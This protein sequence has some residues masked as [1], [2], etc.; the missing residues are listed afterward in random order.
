MKIHPFMKGLILLILVC[1]LTAASGCHTNSPWVLPPQTV[2]FS[3]AEVLSGTWTNYNGRVMRLIGSVVKSSE[4]GGDFMI[5]KVGD[6]ESKE[7]YFCQI[8]QVTH[9]PDD[10]YRGGTHNIY[11]LLARTGD[12]SGHFL[13]GGVKMEDRTNEF[14]VTVDFRVNPRYIRFVPSPFGSGSEATNLARD[15]LNDGVLYDFT[16]TKNYRFRESFWAYGGKP[17]IP[18]DTGLDITNLSRIDR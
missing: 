2:G 12:M 9:I 18:W 1:L 3:G 16:F 6:K 10:Q 13:V 14:I 15:F 17:Q 7:T 5:T 4:K 8:Y 11:S